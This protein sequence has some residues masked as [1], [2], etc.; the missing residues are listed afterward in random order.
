M[1]PSKASRWGGIIAT[2]SVFFR[3]YRISVSGSVESANTLPQG[4][5]RTTAR[6][7]FSPELVEIIDD[8]WLGL[9]SQR[10]GG[11]TQ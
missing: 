1:A 10:S 4:I 6:L 5:V 9:R 8:Y 2:G 7:D 11:L 3:K